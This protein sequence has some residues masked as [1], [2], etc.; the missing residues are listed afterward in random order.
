LEASSVKL[1]VVLRLL[2]AAGWDAFDVSQVV[3]D[4]L[5]DHG[6]VDFVLTAALSRN[7]YCISLKLKDPEIVRVLPSCWK[8]GQVAGF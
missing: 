6:K 4:Y 5:T 3:P 8:P 1:G 7:G 2:N